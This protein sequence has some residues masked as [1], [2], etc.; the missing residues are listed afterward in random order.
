MSLGEEGEHRESKADRKEGR[1][2]QRRS[3]VR[4]LSVELEIE[5]SEIRVLRMFTKWIIHVELRGSSDSFLS[6]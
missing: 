2:L 5:G 3:G 6:N 1:C 4:S